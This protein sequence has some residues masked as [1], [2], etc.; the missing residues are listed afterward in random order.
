MKKTFFKNEETRKRGGI[1]ERRAGFTLIEIIVSLGIFT[2]VAVVAMGAFLKVIDANKKSQSLKTAINNVNFAL[3]S[4]SRELRVGSNYYCFTTSSDLTSLTT[5]PAGYPSGYPSC[6]TTG[7]KGIAFLSSK[8]AVGSG[9]TPCNLIHAFLFDTNASGVTIKKAEQ[10][11]CGGLIRSDS[12]QPIIS[13]DAIIT[14]YNMNVFGATSAAGP[15]PRVFI[16][17]KGYAGVKEKN[18]AYFDV[19]TTVSQRNIF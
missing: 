18:K 12:F 9:G 6:D 8:T 13:P 3:E 7:V 2:I 5:L 1:V 10:D 14:E 16:H 15:Q 11:Q 4:M 19:Q 17:L